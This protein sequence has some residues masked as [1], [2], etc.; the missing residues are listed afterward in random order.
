MKEDEK[1]TLFAVIMTFLGLL[2]QGIFYGLCAMALLKY[3]NS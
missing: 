2:L 1:G 3:I